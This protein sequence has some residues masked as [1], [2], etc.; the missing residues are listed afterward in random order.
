MIGGY[1]A[2]PAGWALDLLARTIDAVA[3]GLLHSFM[4]DP[5]RVDERWCVTAFAALAHR[6]PVEDQESHPGE[7]TARG[8]EQ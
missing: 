3:Q 2:V 7:R 5:R 8:T 4:L 6:P 1:G